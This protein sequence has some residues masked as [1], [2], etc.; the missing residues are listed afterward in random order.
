MDLMAC[1]E[2]S[3]M[4]AARVAA[5]QRLSSAEM[6]IGT[7]Q[8]VESLSLQAR[9][10]ASPVERRSRTVVVVV[11]TVGAIAEIVEI[12][13]TVEI[14]EVAE[15]AMTVEIAAGVMMTIGVTE[16]AAAAA[17]TIV[18]TAMTAGGDTRNV[19]MKCQMSVH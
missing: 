2:Q 17:A 1:Q 16:A 10:S 15:I 6:V 13:E 18:M 7:V 11:A 4:A 5:S 12:A 14:V 8:N 3:T 19:E 9:M